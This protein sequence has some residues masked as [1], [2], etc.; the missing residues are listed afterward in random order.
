MRTGNNALAKST[1]KAF[2]FAIYLATFYLYLKTFCK[3]R[4]NTALNKA[5]SI[6]E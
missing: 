4:S 1:E 3:H 6:Q 5:Q 2:N